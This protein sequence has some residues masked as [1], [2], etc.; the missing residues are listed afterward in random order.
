MSEMYWLTGGASPRAMTASPAT[1][2][3]HL[4]PSQSLVSG[5]PDRVGTLVSAQ[6]E[7]KSSRPSL[8]SGGHNTSQF[9]LITSA[10]GVSIRRRV[11]ASGV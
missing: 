5:P 6:G 1:T 8:N 9:S 11:G 4:P 2:S 7:R 10:K 3:Q